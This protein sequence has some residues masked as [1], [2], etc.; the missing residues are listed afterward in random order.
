MFASEIYFMP[1]DGKQAE[2]RVFDLFSHAKKTIKITIYTFTNK[3]LTK[4]LKIAAKK[5]VKI[6]IL[7][8]KKEA[9]YKYSVIPKLAILK[10]FN[11]YL[12]SGKKYK[13]GNK[14]KMH[15]KAAIIDNTYLII[16]S[17]NYSYSAFY[18][19]YEYIMINTD[20]FLIAQFNAFFNHLKILSTNYRLSR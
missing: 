19:N 3:T 4:A 2:K 9:K 20:K 18:K 16:G 6:V 14:A 10:N 1:H 5:G 17:A 15:V 11:V 12:L 7:A 8:D 13:N